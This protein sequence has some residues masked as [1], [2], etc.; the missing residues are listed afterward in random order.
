MST[1]YQRYLDTLPL[2]S[3]KPAAE[4]EEVLL[5]VPLLAQLARPI[6]SLDDVDSLMLE[7]H[8]AR[9]RGCF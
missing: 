4:K 7:L 1:T 6:T 3:R 8:E 2:G 5:P 9:A